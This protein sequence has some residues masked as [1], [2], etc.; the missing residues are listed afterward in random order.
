[1]TKV[2]N[3]IPS[4]IFLLCS[5][6]IFIG[7]TLLADYL[8]DFIASG[9]KYIVVNSFNFQQLG[10]VRVFSRSILSEIIVNLGILTIIVLIF[11]KSPQAFFLVNFSKQDDAESM[12]WVFFRVTKN[13]LLTSIVLMFLVGNLQGLFWWLPKFLFGF[14]AQPLHPEYIMDFTEHKPSEWDYIWKNDKRTHV[15]IDQI[16]KMYFPWVSSINFSLIFLLL[17]RVGIFIKII[18]VFFRK[19]LNSFALF[20]ALL[21]FIFLASKIFIPKERSQNL[22]NQ[23]IEKSIFKENLPSGS[24]AKETPK[25]HIEVYDSQTGEIRTS[26]S[27]K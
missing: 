8:S 14:Y 16:F 11:F 4:K 12:W 22:H 3:L 13:F 19:S 23:E 9:V 10:F 20:L 21:P 1:M 24:K 25:I 18:K 17:I 7:F 2:D 27:I 26:N 15:T 5:L 6:I